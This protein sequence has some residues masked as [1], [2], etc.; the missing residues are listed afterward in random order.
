VDV[1]RQGGL[2]A[3]SF[4]HVSTTIELPPFEAPGGAAFPF[5]DSIEVS[6]SGTG[7][8]MLGTLLAGW[9]LFVGGQGVARSSG[10][11]VWARAVH[12]AKVAV[13]Y[14][15]LTLILSFLA[16][17]EIEIPG[18]GGFPGGVLE[19]RPSHFSAFLWPFLIAAV[20]GVAGGVRTAREDV[21]RP[22]WGRWT[23]SA[24]AGGWRMAWVGVALAFVG[25]LVVAAV[26]PQQTRA[27]FDFVGRLGWAGGSWLVL[28]TA[29]FLPNASTW[30]LTGAM[31]GSA[32]SVGLFGSSCEVLSFWRFPA[33][34]QDAGAPVSPELL[35]DPCGLLLGAFRF[36]TAPAGYFLFLL[37]PVAV[38]L[39]GGWLAARRFGAG[40]G[41]LGAAVGA[42]S[43]VA[44]ALFA[45]GLMF[46]SRFSG[47]VEGALSLFLG[48]QGIAL[49]PGM[50]GG[51]LLALLWGTAAGAAGGWMAGRA[52]PRAREEPG[53]V[54]KSI[55][56]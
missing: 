41:I 44:F 52:T 56:D 19:V 27:Y 39:L 8:L 24:L 36:E 42:A 11:P 21:M 12:G 28:T 51:F 26:H 45:L 34:V 3:L 29:L 25:F 50:L 5:G 4:H 30:I 7:T 54:Q 40:R 46:L 20:V 9:L 53:P 23:W 6:F 37:V 43:G 1:L 15:V 47:D 18:G 2:T 10:G 17:Q 14:A 16:I 32:A 13:P 22:R 31:G 55:W 35:D 49:G 38:T 48:G 33:G